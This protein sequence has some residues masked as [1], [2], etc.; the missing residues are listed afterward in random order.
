MGDKK[1][2][3]KIAKQ[4]HDLKELETICSL[5]KGQSDARLE[6]IWYGIIKPAMMRKV[7]F[8]CD[9]DEFKNSD[10]YDT[11]YRHLCIKLGVL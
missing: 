3:D 7:G 1:T 5:V 4:I 10:D 2:F 8:T 9:D 11:V 6:S